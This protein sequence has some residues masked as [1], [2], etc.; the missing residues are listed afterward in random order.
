[1]Q[2]IN[3]RVNPR[4]DDQRLRLRVGTS[5]LCTIVLVQALST[6]LMLH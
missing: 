2:T 6:L 4:D 5:L 1:M 3:K